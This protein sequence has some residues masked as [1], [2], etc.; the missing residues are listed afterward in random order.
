MLKIC[1]KFNNQMK[2]PNNQFSSPKKPPSQNQC[3]DEWA[4]IEKLK[5]ERNQ[6][7]TEEHH[8]NELENFELSSYSDLSSDSQTELPIE[9][10][11][12]TPRTTKTKED[13]SLLPH[14]GKMKKAPVSL[15]KMKMSKMSNIKSSRPK[16]AMEPFN[17][18]EERD[19]HFIDNKGNFLYK[20]YNAHNDAWLLSL[21]EEVSDVNILKNKKKIYEYAMNKKI[22]RARSDESSVISVDEAMTS[23]SFKEKKIETLKTTLLSLLETGE[24]ANRAINRIHRMIPE[25]KSFKP[26]KKNVRKN[27]TGKQIYF[28]IFQLILNSKNLIF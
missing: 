16:I 18:R 8:M 15:K 25:K 27:K 23:E 12:S 13:P 2:K 17:M 26:Y 22:L 6:Y 20:N 1:L 19:N 5:R 10:L 21:D 7:R 28:V 14:P 11:N 4:R 24:S 3:I 9:R